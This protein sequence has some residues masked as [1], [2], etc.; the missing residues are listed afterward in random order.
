VE[1]DRVVAVTGAGG[2]GSGYLLTSRL[3]LTSAHVV[4]TEAGAV[5]V[6][7]PG[8]PETFSATVVWCGTPGGRDDAALA[9]IDT[10]APTSA[11]LA[12]V[13]WGR[14]VTFEPEIPCR[15]WG[16]PD[17]V[18]QAG[19]PVDVEQPH[20]TL[21]PGDRIVGDRYVMRLSGH[22][23]THPSGRGSPWAGM[24][25]A[26]VYCGDLLAGV[27]VADPARRGH[28]ALEAVPA[29]LLLRDPRFRSVVREYAGADWLRCEAIE[30]QGLMDRQSPLRS[31]APVRTPAT[32]LSARRAVVPFHGR[33]EVLREL[34]AWARHPGLSVWLLY[35]P[36]GQGKTR[37]AHH[38][39]EALLDLGW[40]VLWLDSAA[41]GEALSVLSAVST[42]L[43]VVVDYA[44]TR[45]DQSAE[46][47][48]LLTVG[49]SP[50]AVKV[51]L[52]AR[53]KGP[54]WRAL[55]ATGDA[56]AEALEAARCHELTA[57]DSTADELHR[58]FRSAV[59]GLARA[60]PRLETHRDID[61][62]AVADTVATTTPRFGAQPTAL[63]VQML[64]LAGLLDAAAAIRHGDPGPTATPALPSRAPVEGRRVEDRLLD[65][66]RRYWL[67]TARS[68]GL[69]DI[70][71][72][73]AATDIVAATVVLAPA[74]HHGLVDVLR[75]IPDVADQPRLVIAA[76]RDWLLSLYPGLSPGAYGGFGPDRLAEHL[77][78]ELIA[79]GS[80]PN[81]IETLA[82]NIDDPA[83][84]VNFVV[85]CARA[86]ADTSRTSLVGERLSA[87]CV[88]RPQTLLIA[89]IAA[90]PFVE[91]PAP[92]LRAIAHVADNPPAD[93]DTLAEL[94]FCFPAPTLI[95]ADAATA[96][97]RA[98]VDRLHG[99]NRRTEA[100]T[101]LLAVALSQLSMHLAAAQRESEALAA[102]EEA[103]KRY[104]GLTPKSPE[105]AHMMTAVS[106]RDS[107]TAA[108]ALHH[109][110]RER[111]ATK[112]V[113][114]SIGLARKLAD[115]DRDQYLP[116]LAYGLGRR[117]AMLFPDRPSQALMSAREAVE[118]WRG[119]AAAEPD[120]YSESLATEL[121]N[122]STILRALGHAAAA[123]T[124][125]EE[126]V[127]LA[128]HHVPGERGE[129][130]LVNLTDALLALG[131]ALSELGRHE[132]ALA[133]ADELVSLQRRLCARRPEAFRRPLAVGL[134]L[135]AESAARLER[136]DEALPSIAEAIAL[137]HQM[138]ESP[139]PRGEMQ[140]ELSGVYSLLSKILTASHR[141][142]EAVAASMN[143]AAAQ[144][145][146]SIAAGMDFHYV[147]VP[148]LHK[149]AVRWVYGA[150]VS[151]WLAALAAVL[152]SLD[153]PA[154]DAQIALWSWVWS[155][156]VGIGVIA[157]ALRRTSRRRL[158]L[159]HIMS[160]MRTELAFSVTGW[161]LL[162][163]KAVTARLDVGG[164]PAAVTALGGLVW[165][166]ALLARTAD[167][168]FTGGGRGG[169]R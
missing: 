20:G 16:R 33:D 45:P 71:T 8:R 94:V 101:A 99:I 168:R 26:A 129:R 128:R 121:R 35:G 118:M 87:W 50:V 72:I 106:V 164:T 51:L 59:A 152:V 109:A 34:H 86:A 4:A 37:L 88:E 92:L 148:W 100:E 154:I 55:A 2:S 79:D 80:R 125:A 53:T 27:V 28:A 12:P 115:A 149:T 40:T 66:E 117:A 131:P 96:L 139:D 46:L 10:A 76:L 60:L 162:A 132:Q 145:E 6:F 112:A 58:A 48:S 153:H 126:A 151:A 137:Y 65:H 23:P 17:L 63:S 144:R 31:Q 15:T 11:A 113:E 166:V 122:L 5:T 14:A 32:L 61:W 7:R 91:V 134:A 161:T 98:L 160:R 103:A 19:R 83:H 44:E 163:A 9:L 116:M 158:L 120:E 41:R 22:P 165:L 1:W 138:R 56:V 146:F 78:A 43:L 119:L 13:M 81:V 159:S 102:A 135:R 141:Y 114:H 82:R 167:R 155:T 133:A 39:G 107:L 47:L 84:L 30:L 36:A 89:A 140:A 90:A 147:V 68:T 136:Y 75:R 18:Q 70:L 77:V 69:A 57:L 42:N 74:D 157:V 93:L 29:Y 108:M 97:T 127:E 38:F 62:D 142:D 111:A 156:I 123:V 21:N 64:A 104:R 130:R 3:L 110:G 24:S 25:G 73:D 95:L 85:V 124:A 52:L 105:H 54:W 67:T 49:S 169:S 143:A 150:T